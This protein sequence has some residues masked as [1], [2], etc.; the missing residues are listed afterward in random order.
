MAEE[1]LGGT[2]VVCSVDWVGVIVGWVGWMDGWWVET[3][4]VLSGIRKICPT[5]RLSGLIRLLA[6]TMASIETLCNSL[7][8]VTVS[9]D[10]TVWLVKAGVVGAAVT[11]GN[12]AVGDATNCMGGVTVGSGVRLAVGIAGVAGVMVAAIVVGCAMMS[13]DGEMACLRCKINKAAPIKMTRTI[14]MAIKRLAVLRLIVNYSNWRVGRRQQLL[15]AVHTAHS[16]LSGTAPNP[17]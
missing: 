7:I 10:C 11:M 5:A 17:H 3:G 12:T 15:A 16:S 9:P 4:G 13:V 8:L 2:A 1:G 6:D 14:R